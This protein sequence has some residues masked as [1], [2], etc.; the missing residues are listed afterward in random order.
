MMNTDLKSAT[1]HFVWRRSRY[2]MVSALAGF[3]AIMAGAA[4]AMSAAEAEARVKVSF[5]KPEQFAT[6]LRDH[7]SPERRD[8]VLAELGKYVQQAAAPRL[9]PGQSLQI[10]VLDLK[11]AGSPAR[12][13]G[14]ATGNMRV[15]RETDPP[16]IDLGFRVLDASGAIVRMEK[17]RRLR[18][19]NYLSH[20][21]HSNSDPLRYEKRLLDD[22]I[23]RDFPVPTN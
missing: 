7:E 4:D 21:D 2:L 18:D 23:D 19:M 9:P 20:G 15:I 17:K 13:A 12:N 5:I 6:T 16:R 14:G 22:W 3:L 11:R 10:D 1:G 8:A